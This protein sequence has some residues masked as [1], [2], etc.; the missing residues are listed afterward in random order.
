MGHKENIFE[1]LGALGLDRED[2]V[3]EQL[4]KYVELW[5]KWNQKIRLTSKMTEEEFLKTQLAN[6]LLLWKLFDEAGSYLDVGSGA[7]LPGIPLSLLLR[8]KTVLVESNYK[9]ASFLNVCKR[10]LKIFWLQVYN[11]RVEEMKGTE[12]PT[13]FRYITARAV[14]PIKDVLRWTSDFVGDDSALIL[15]KGD[16]ANAELYDARKIVDSLGLIVRIEKLPHPFSARPYQVVVL[17]KNR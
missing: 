11:G 2:E 13:A 8:D 5:L 15:P 14:A 7:G 3:V 4:E 9:K 17:K 6:S 1:L 10:E 12:Q 16:R